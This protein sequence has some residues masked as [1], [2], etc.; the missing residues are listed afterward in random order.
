MKS[1]VSVKRKLKVKSLKELVEKIKSSISLKM[2]K[3]SNV[4]QSSLDKN[5]M[6]FINGKFLLI[7]FTKLLK[8]Q[9]LSV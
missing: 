2:T 8:S 1:E 6:Y 9:Y 5:E 4:K 7:K 3:I